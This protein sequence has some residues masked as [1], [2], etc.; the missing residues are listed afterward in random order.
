[1]SCKGFSYNDIFLKIRIVDRI[2]I[3]LTKIDVHKRAPEYQ[4]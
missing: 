3:Q 4:G 2:P 1:M